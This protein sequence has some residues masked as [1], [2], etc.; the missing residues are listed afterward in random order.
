MIEKIRFRKDDTL[1]IKKLVF[2][3]F[4]SQIKKWW[5][6]LHD[7]WVTRL[8]SRNSSW[9][10]QKS[11]Q[12]KQW[13]GGSWP[14]DVSLSHHKNAVTRCASAVIVFLVT[15][16]FLSLLCGIN[17]CVFV[18]K[19]KETY[20]KWYTIMLPNKY[21][22]KKKHYHCHNYVTKQA[23]T[24]KTRNSSVKTSHFVIPVSTARLGIFRPGDHPRKR[25][26]GHSGGG[27]ASENPRGGRYIPRKTKM[28]SWKIPIFNRIY[29]STHSWWIFQRS[30]F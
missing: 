25:R 14:F 5:C 4:V 12:I 19:W 9:E 27:L 28:T 8:K 7:F 10:L 1:H 3:R 21:K 16:C 20:C 11:S 6:S 17:T 23:P 18:N 24:K 22:K 26:E 30:S 2:Q 15:Q 13:V 29:T